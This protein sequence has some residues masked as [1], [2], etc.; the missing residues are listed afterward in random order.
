MKEDERA[1]LVTHL[2]E[3]RSRLLRILLYATAGLVLAWAFYPWIYRFLAAPVMGPLRAAGGQLTVRGLLEGFWVRCVISLVVGCF[4]ASPFIF[5]E[6]WAFVAPGLTPRERRAGAPLLPVATLLFLGGVALGYAITRP[7]VS[8]LLKF[9]PPDTAALLTL[10]DTLV[11][12]LKFYLAFGLSFQLP[13]VIIFLASIGL[14]RY[15]LLIGRWRE[16]V[17]AIFVIAA[18]ITPTW[19]P[20][21]MTVCALPMVLLYALTTWVVKV[22]ERR[23]E[24]AQA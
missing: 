18:I 24:R 8:W 9:V 17:V 11:L 20:L 16:A 7:S 6:T 3:L 4:V 21:T 19:D 23:R 10:N 14:I 12:L 5:Y 1:D 13:L 15:S 22:I 2:E